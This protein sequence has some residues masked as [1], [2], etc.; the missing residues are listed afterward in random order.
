MVAVQG[1]QE[2]GQ[3]GQKAGKRQARG[4]AEGARGVAAIQVYSQK[5]AGPPHARPCSVVYR[6]SYMLRFLYISKHPYI[7]TL[8]F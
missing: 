4:V 3:G 2:A 1:G 8:D 7:N 5:P 6:S